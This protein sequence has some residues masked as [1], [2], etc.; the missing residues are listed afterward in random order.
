MTTAQTKPTT[1]VREF[2]QEELLDMLGTW[3]RIQ[4]EYDASEL[5]SS[6]ARPGETDD[7]FLQRV[8][9]EIGIQ[10]LLEQ[11]GMIPTI[12]YSH[13]E[14]VAEMEARFAEW[15]REDAA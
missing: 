9:D 4:A 12:R 14:M 5:P 15:D 6:M 8:I 10:L 1:S 11:T 13:E 7:E 2:S 3:E